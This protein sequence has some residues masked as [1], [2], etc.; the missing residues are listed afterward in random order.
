ME[1]LL[2]HE[3]PRVGDSVAHSLVSGSLLKKSNF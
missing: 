3:T 2:F 1:D